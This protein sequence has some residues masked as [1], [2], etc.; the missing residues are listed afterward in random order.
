MHPKTFDT[1]AHPTARELL[2]KEVSQSEALWDKIKYPH[3]LDF[4]S[5]I[6]LL[7]G[8]LNFEIS[9]IFGVY[10]SICHQGDK[11]EV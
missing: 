7:I 3:Y 9:A 2:L 4:R 1:L 8:I 5:K 11:T 10:K 6:L